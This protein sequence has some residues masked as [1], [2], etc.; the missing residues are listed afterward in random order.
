M[1]RQFK[2]GGL[3]SGFWGVSKLP[4]TE[5]LYHYPGSLK[6]PYYVLGWILGTT[7]AIAVSLSGIPATPTNF[8]KRLHCP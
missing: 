7:L 5:Q 1:Q 2:Q 6:R 8:F 3:V 4:A